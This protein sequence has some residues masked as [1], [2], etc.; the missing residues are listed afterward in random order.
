MR[1]L[2]AAYAANGDVALAEETFTRRS[3]HPDYIPS[4]LALADLLMSGRGEEAQPVADQLVTEQPGDVRSME[5]AFRIQVQRRDLQAAQSA[6][7]ILEMRPIYRRDR[8]WSGSSMRQK[9]NSPRHCADSSA[10]VHWRPVRS[11]PLPP[12]RASNWRN[13]RRN[14]H[15]RAWIRRWLHLRPRAAVGPQVRD[16]GAGRALR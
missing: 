6:Q 8:F 10:P 15:W 12:L 9:A 3:A 1:T 4:R 16:P 11:S 5:A 2:S 14:G 7:Q 13:I